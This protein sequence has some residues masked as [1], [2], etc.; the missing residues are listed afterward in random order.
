MRPSLILTVIDSAAVAPSAWRKS[1][2]NDSK[3]R[4]LNFMRQKYTDAKN[5]A[6]EKGGMKTELETE[7]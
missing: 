7:I 1:A 4:R 2:A 3:K 6:R 5:L